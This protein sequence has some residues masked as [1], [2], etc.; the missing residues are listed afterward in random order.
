MG[1]SAV[2]SIVSVAGTCLFIAVLGRLGRADSPGVQDSTAAQPQRSHRIPFQLSGNRIALD[3]RVNGSGP[4]SFVLDTGASATILDTDQ[5]ERLGLRLEGIRDAN[6]PADLRRANGV[7]LSL[8]GVDLRDQ[9]ILV[10]DL[11][12]CENSAEG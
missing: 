9:A 1:R 11:V 5:A 2:T 8:P 12:R 4:L 7:S 3:V 6:A 10:R